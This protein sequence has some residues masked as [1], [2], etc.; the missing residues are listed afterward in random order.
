MAFFMLAS[1]GAWW[2]HLGNPG[3]GPFA[4][5]AAVFGLACVAKFSAV[6]LLPMMALCALALIA[7]GRA[8]VPRVLLSAAG[9]AAAAVL[10]I[11]A[12]YGFRYS[13][14]NPALPPADQFIESWPDM[15]AHTGRIGALIHRMADARLLPEAFLYGAAYVVQTSQVRGAFLNGEYSVEG[16]RTFFLWAFALKTTIPLMAACVASLAVGAAALRRTGPGLRARLLALLPFTPLAALFAVYWAASVTSHLNIGHRHLLPAYPPLYILTGALGALFTRPMRLSGALAAVLVAWHA[17]ESALVAPNYIAYF[18][19]FAGGPGGGYLHLV[20]S[21]LDWGQ[22]LPGLKAWLDRNAAPGEA[23]Y[24]AYFGTGEPRYYG[25]P[26]RR[27]AYMNGFHEDEPYIPLGPGLYCV[28]AT[29]LQQ[30]YSSVRGPW[31]LEQEKE[32]EFLRTFEPAFAAYASD[33][34][35]RASLDREL[36]PEKWKASRDRFLHLRFARLCHYLR[37]RRPDAVIGYSIFV[38]R[39]GA[40]EVSGATEGPLK[41][42]ISLI[43]RSGEGRAGP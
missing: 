9:H 18:N 14:F 42:W 39:L 32:Y 31:T 33:P 10:V 35:A 30:V 26:A 3:P 41:D 23:V 27:L 22:D 2:R 36:T 43:S 28:G 15:Y 34:S 29:M 6:L 1:V 12:L 24:L 21:S 17:A 38:Y 13:A 37:V 16:W 7:A 40:A 5:S 25:I 8:S 11:W 20:D 4:L 19:E